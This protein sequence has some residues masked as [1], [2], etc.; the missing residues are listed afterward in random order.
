MPSARCGARFGT[1][2]HALL[3]LDAQADERADHAADLD[4]FV[5]REVA[6]MLNLDLALGVLVHGQRIDDAHRAALLQALKL[7]DD[8]AVELRVPE[9]EHDQLNRPDGH[10]SASFVADAA[11]V[12]HNDHPRIGRIG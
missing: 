12:T 11:T 5:L 4:R 3:A 2:V 1:G 10:G 7:G 8:L 9:P 6:Q